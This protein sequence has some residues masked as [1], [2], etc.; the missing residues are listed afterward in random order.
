[1]QRGDVLRQKGSNPKL[2]DEL[3]HDGQEW[4][5]LRSKLQYQ[6]ERAKHFTTDYSNRHGD[7]GALDGCL[8]TLREFSDTVGE[9][10]SQLDDLS[11]S[12]IQMVRCQ[13]N[14]VV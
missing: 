4:V 2:L 9:K 11:K 1:M 6:I 8:Q 7:L 10:I 13:A 12:L 14:L 5:N 3:L